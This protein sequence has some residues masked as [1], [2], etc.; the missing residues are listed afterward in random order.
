MVAMMAMVEWLVVDEIAML[1][2]GILYLV[3]QLDRIHEDVDTGKPVVLQTILLVKLWMVD[4]CRMESN[5][6]S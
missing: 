1:G 3:A 5:R 4:F 6:H 2:K